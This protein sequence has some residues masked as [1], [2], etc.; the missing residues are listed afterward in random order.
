MHRLGIWAAA[1]AGHLRRIESL[2][3]RVAAAMGISAA[4]LL[5]SSILE[6][7]AT[8]VFYGSLVLAVCCIVVGYFGKSGN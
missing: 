4:V 5:L 2:R 3:L 7:L 6:A 8:A 1:A